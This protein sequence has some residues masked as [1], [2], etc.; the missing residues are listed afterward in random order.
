MNQYQ[1]KLEKLNVAIR[2]VYEDFNSYIQSVKK[3]ET[4][5]VESVDSKH[6]IVDECI[7]IIEDIESVI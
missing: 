6:K 2:N 3:F 1:Q 7:D 4:N 5:S